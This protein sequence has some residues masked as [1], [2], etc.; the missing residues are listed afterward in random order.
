MNGNSF[1]AF[2]TSAGAQRKSAASRRDG[3][4]RTR[5]TCRCDAALANNAMNPTAENVRECAEVPRRSR[6]RPIMR[7]LS[8][9][10]APQTRGAAGERGAVGPTYFHA[11][12]AKALD[13]FS[14][15]GTL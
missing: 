12:D 14:A 5:E 15:V 3:S 8:E 11:P 6:R 2:E 13:G 1:A 4:G 7:T 9:R 10:P